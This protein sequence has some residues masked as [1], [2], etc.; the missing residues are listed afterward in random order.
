MDLK[1]RSPAEIA[2]VGRRLLVIEPKRSVFNE[3]HEDAEIAV[4]VKS[5]KTV[6]EISRVTRNSQ[7]MASLKL[8]VGECELNVVKFLRAT[9][10]M[11]ECGLTFSD[12]LRKAERTC[13]NTTLILIC[14]T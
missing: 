11:F 3:L 13:V 9:D 7:R 10:L 8:E 5:L 14:W 6:K 4:V 12:A 1:R 2:G